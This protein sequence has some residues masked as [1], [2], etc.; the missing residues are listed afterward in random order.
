[1]LFSESV[2]LVQSFRRSA[3]SRL[4]YG[5]APDLPSGVRAIT[6]TIAMVGRHE[7]VFL[8]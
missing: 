5:L 3:S 2:M 7:F 6:A 4:E 1:M 8:Y